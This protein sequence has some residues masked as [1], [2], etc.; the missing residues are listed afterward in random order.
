MNTTIRNT[1]AALLMS[2]AGAGLVACGG[3]T[4]DVSPATSVRK[5][6]KPAEHQGYKDLAEA[7]RLVDRPVKPFEH[8]QRIRRGG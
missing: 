2:A 5:E 7:P 4:V 1:L 8:Q 3:E 6:V